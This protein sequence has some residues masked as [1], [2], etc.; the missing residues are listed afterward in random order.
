[1]IKG[2]WKE[3]FTDMTSARFFQWS[4]IQWSKFTWSTDKTPKLMKRQVRIRNV[5]KAAFR[6]ENAS[7]N[8]PFGLYEFGFEY[9]TGAY[10][11]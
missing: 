3:I 2:V 11:R 4:A 9:I 10:Y 8:E 6:L 7:L 5:D 1:M